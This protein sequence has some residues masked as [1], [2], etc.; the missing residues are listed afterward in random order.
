M[1][2]GISASKLQVISLLI[3]SGTC[4][5]ELQSAD[6]RKYKP[7]LF[8]SRGSHAQRDEAAVHASNCRGRDGS[9]DAGAAG[10]E[11]CERIR[12]RGGAD[13]QQRRDDRVLQKAR[14]R[15]ARVAG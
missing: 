2:D 8:G 13:A 3:L 4:R 1:T 5:A 11:P 9:E 6:A 14:L 7:D 10:D 12:P 15:D